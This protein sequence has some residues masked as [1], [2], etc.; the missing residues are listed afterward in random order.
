IGAHLV[1][2]GYRLQIVERK[3][4]GLLKR[5]VTF[6]PIP[7]WDA[8]IAK[9]APFSAAIVDELQQLGQLKVSG[10]NERLLSFAHA[11]G[12][13]DAEANALNLLA[14][15]PYQLDI[16]GEGTLGTRSFKIRFGATDGGVHIR[17][18]FSEGLF[19][20]VDRTYRVTGLLY[21]ILES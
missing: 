20:C 5:R 15:F 21:K 7:S 6:V 14:P 12:L 10:I 2:G 16:Q 4:D 18:E 1:D 3:I 13:E 9:L 19:K 17:G 8:G 11:A